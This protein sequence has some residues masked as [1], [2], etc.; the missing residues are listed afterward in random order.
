MLNF[1]R[2]I[3]RPAVLEAQDELGLLRYEEPGAGERILAPRDKEHWGLLYAPSPKSPVDTSGKGGKPQSFAARY[4]SAKVLAMVRRDRNHPSLVLY[5]LQNEIWPDLSN[6]KIFY[7]LRRMH[8]IDPTRIILLKSGIEP[9]NQAWMEPY[10]DKIRVD[11]GTGFSGWWDRHT[12]GGPGVLNDSFYRGP[13]KMTPWTE[14]KREIV[15]WGEMLG[16][17]TPDDHGAIVSRYARTGRR[18]YDRADHER[19]LG[20]YRSFLDRWGFTGAFPTP[21]EL[22]RS[23]GDRAYAFWGRIVEN[24]RVGGRTDVMVLSG[25]ESTTINNHSGLVDAHRNLKGDAELLRFYTRPLHLAVKA[26]DLVVERGGKVACDV[27]LAGRLS[28]EGDAILILRSRDPAGRIRGRFRKKIRLLPGDARTRLIAGGLVFSIET[29]GY[30]RIEGEIR[31]GTKSLVQGREEVFGVKWRLPS[32]PP[33]NK[34]ALVDPRGILAEVLSG[35]GRRYPHFR[36]DLPELDVIAAAPPAGTGGTLLVKRP[37]EGTGDDPLYQTEEN[38]PAGE[39]SY[40][41]RDLPPGVYQVT[42]K[43]AEIWHKRKGARVFDVALNG[44]TV[45]R[46]FDVLAEAAGPDRAVDRTF[47]VEVGREGRIRIT[48]P[49]SSIDRPKISALLVR[50]RGLVRAVNCGGK[51]YRD[52]KG[53]L[54]GPRPAPVYLEEE[55]LRRVKEE[56]TTLVLL[57]ETDTGAGGAARELARRGVWKYAGLVGRSR[58]PWMGAWYFNRPH[59]LFRGLPSGKVLSWVYQPAGTKNGILLDGKGVRIPMGYGRDHGTRL[60]AGCAIAPYGKGKVILFCVPG[61]YSALSGKGR[62]FHPL[63]ARRILVNALSWGALRKE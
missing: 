55:W 9:R 18:G 60:G 44:K 3:G 45:L 61:L 39:L 26:R 28:L 13:G 21:S 40:T 33:E 50:G 2:C 43:F 31:R 20:A 54:W 38:A 1:H 63:A 37:I 58:A 30:W 59:P 8:E 27:Y 32:L 4:E 57:P 42:L 48:F 14:N 56:G 7:T 25:W 5:C 52:E 62:S 23:A 22:F 36:K 29:P 17:S 53:L 12:V 19:I 49:R 35:A 51:P 24:G 41:F 6:P 47:P 16:S 46:N 15:M 10:S 11:D 34:A